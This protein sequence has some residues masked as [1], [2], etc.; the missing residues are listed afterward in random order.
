MCPDLVY[1]DAGGLEID[2]AEIRS[3]NALLNQTFGFYG[4]YC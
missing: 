4:G 2:E 1:K 3:A